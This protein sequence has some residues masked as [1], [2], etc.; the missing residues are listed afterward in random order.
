MK[1]RSSA[2]A[3]L[4]FRSFAILLA[5]L[6][7]FCLWQRPYA[8]LLA[9][10]IVVHAALQLRW[11]LVWLAS[12]PALLP[13][14]DW[15]PWSGWLPLQEFEIFMLGILAVG[16][17]NLPQQQKGGRLATSSRVLLGAYCL[18]WLAALFIGGDGGQAGL[19]ESGSLGAMNVLRGAKGF[20]LALLLL[21]LLSRAWSQREQALWRYFVPGAILGLAIVAL[22]VI[23]ERWLFTGLSDFASD[24]RAVGPFYE[25]FA[26]GAALD[27]YLSALL[28]VCVWWLMQRRLDVWS[29][30]GGAV[31]ALATYAALVSFSR[32]VYLACVVTA[33]VLAWAQHRVHRNASGRTGV[34][35]YL[36]LL[37]GGYAMSLVF[38]FGG[39]RT[40]AAALLALLAA[41]ALAPAARLRLA[42]AQG[43]I[44]SG[45]I[46]L[47]LAIALVLPKGP[48][49]ATAVAALITLA[50][51]AWGRFRGEGGA[52][53]SWAGAIGLSLATPLV[54]AYWRADGEWLPVLGWLVYVW[55]TLLLARLAGWW[56][57]SYAA[58]AMPGTLVLMLGLIVPVVGNYYM[59]A[60]FSTAATDLEGRLSH[61]GDVAALS[62]TSAA[63]LAGNG[64]GRF[65]DE[66]YW[67]N[68]R[69][70]Q[71]SA[72]ALGDDGQ[73]YVRLIPPH[74]MR[75]FEDVV[76]LSQ[77]IDVG[78]TPLTLHLRVRSSAADGVL[79]ASVCDKWLLYPF[80]CIAGNVAKLGKSWQE[81]SIP[82]RG[83]R[84]IDGRSLI[85]PAVLMLSSNNTNQSHS[86]DIA[87][88]RLE[89]ANGQS[90]LKNGNFSGGL[91]YWYYTSDRH[92]L[93]WH[94][95]NLLLHVYF[96]QGLIGVSLF[97]L[98]CLSACVALLSRMQRADQ[99]APMFLAS[100]MAVLSVGLFDSLLDFTRINVLIFLL[101]W[102]SLMRTQVGGPC[103]ARSAR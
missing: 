96:E 56:R 78:A 21:P 17:W 14:L 53:M 18:S 85:R 58:L 88:L 23:L 59:G 79:H 103:P 9:V 61:W 47:T 34:V 68:R 46:L 43:L 22:A 66:Y 99:S 32:G 75:G 40:L 11:P 39:Y 93:P 65:V 37:A 52:W 26:G 60:R 3:L 48:Y 81:V 1:N 101:L 100:L 64:V 92:H 91:N 42:P 74:T 38:H 13:L 102:L 73:A 10:I 54:A 55:T 89:D 50:G 83:Q 20:I 19:T 80:N 84:Q 76:R 36:W 90:L 4:G 95:K 98:L 15:S 25:M 5:G 71:P 62:R 86:I 16:Y 28:P 30:L 69:A 77:R 8:P 6:M 24:Y 45:L 7:V 41:L 72:L 97:V 29:A 70:E 2:A 33:I 49:L 94:A 82:L 57:Q 31:L 87:D 67:H 12:L 27:C 63:V 44:A 35:S 51:L